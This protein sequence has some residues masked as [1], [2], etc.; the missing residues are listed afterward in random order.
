MK[1]H[2]FTLI[3]LLVVIAI[4]AILAAIL[5]PVFAKAREKA[6]QTA[7]LNNQKQLA[8]AILMKVQDNDEI[9]PASNTL[10][11]ALNMDKGVLMCPTAGTKI[12]NAYV[13]NNKYGNT[14]LGEITTPE[15]AILTGDGIHT[16]TA[17][18][19]TFDQTFDNIAYE[20]TDF[21]FR[22]NG[23][24][25][26]SYVDG[27]AELTAAPA[28]ELSG[29][30]GINGMQLY[31]PSGKEVNMSCFPG[32]SIGQSANLG[33]AGV[34]GQYQNAGWFNQDPLN[35]MPCYFDFTFPSSQTVYKIHWVTYGQENI[36]GTNMWRRGPSDYSIYVSDNQADLGKPT[37]L[38]A[39]FSGDN[40]Y[41]MSHT[42][43]PKRGKYCRVLVTKLIDPRPVFSGGPN[44]S[45][46]MTSMDMYSLDAK[47]I[48]AGYPIS[49]YGSG[50]GR[51]SV[52]SGTWRT[53]ERDLT[54]GLAYMLN[55][56]KRTDGGEGPDMARLTMDGGGNSGTLKLA[57]PASY[58]V[59]HVDMNCQWHPQTVA[60]SYSL[61]DVSY[62]SAGSASGS[63][64][65]YSATINAKAKFIKLAVTN[66]G[67]GQILLRGVAAYGTPTTQ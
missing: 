14:A 4:I 61:D 12:K 43:T 11:G 39:S 67:G 64:D 2:G 18:D 57:L 49:M 48:D 1:R 45:I 24:V 23:N 66:P 6:R 33:G 3:E 59:S 27:H 9:F 53:W 65:I 15:S 40:A 20:M 17:A 52:A 34:F 26:V 54:T 31:Y 35:S 44:S 47:R 21:D 36:N 46:L 60:V 38:A 37:S 51:L 28:G 41:A 50:G 16:A 8:T 13:F 7:C 55:D 10:W 42:F 25:I 29:R 5:F 58:L 19:S 32:T 56:Y 30:P 62:A 63:G 22:H